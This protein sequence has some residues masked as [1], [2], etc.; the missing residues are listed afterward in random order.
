MTTFLSKWR[1]R[2]TAHGGEFWRE[3]LSG[4]AQEDAA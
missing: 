1:V 3:G 4:G 2:A